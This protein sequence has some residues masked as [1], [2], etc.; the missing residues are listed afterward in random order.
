MKF[1]KGIIVGTAVAAT[2]TMM[3]NE[4]MLSTK[5][6]MRKSRKMAKKIGIV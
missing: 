5:K 2:V 4:G 1:V 6:I 3:C